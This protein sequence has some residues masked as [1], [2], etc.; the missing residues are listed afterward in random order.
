M[1]EMLK[2][3]RINIYHIEPH[4][5]EYKK[6]MNF[7]RIIDILHCGDAVKVV[8]R[9]GKLASSYVLYLDHYPEEIVHLGIAQDQAN[10]LWYPE[11]LLINK[12]YNV[13]AYIRDQL[14]VDIIEMTVTT[15]DAEKS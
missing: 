10:G 1:Y 11:S 7:S 2:D 8:K 3:G 14:P 9:I 15:F 13:D 6:V 4:K 5:E 12:K